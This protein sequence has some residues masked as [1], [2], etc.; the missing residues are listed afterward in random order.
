MSRRRGLDPAQRTL[1]ADQ[2]ARAIY[3][4]FERRKDQPPALLGVV[5]AEGRRHVDE[6]RVVLRQDIVE[7]ALEPVAGSVELVDDGSFYRYDTESTSL[8]HSLRTIVQRA[9]AQDRLIVSWSCFD[10]DR[11]VEYGELDDATLH[12]FHRRFRNGIATARRWRRRVQPDLVFEWETF[13]GS[14]KLSRYFE[15]IEF[16]VPGRYGTGL[17]AENIRRVQAGLEKQQTF[18]KL[19]PSQQRAWRDVLEHNRYD[20]VGLRQVVTRAAGEL[21][22]VS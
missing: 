20:C 6:E 19:T 3:I 2:A 10:R 11:V 18:A 1:T 14:N 9:V 17:V 22:A 5:Y 8:R 12:A 21:A 4:D 7:P 16:A 13:G 15:L